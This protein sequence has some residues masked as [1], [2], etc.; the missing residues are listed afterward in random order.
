MIGS[1]ISLQLPLLPALLL[2]LLLLN[3]KGKENRA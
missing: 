2:A 3:R 1:V